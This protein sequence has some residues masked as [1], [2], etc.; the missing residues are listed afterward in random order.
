MADRNARVSY[1]AVHLSRMH[2]HEAMRSSHASR[3]SP[4]GA[5]AAAA[6]A[7]SGDAVVSSLTV[8]PSVRSLSLSFRILSLLPVSCRALWSLSLCWHRGCSAS[9]RRRRRPSRHA[10]PAAHSNPR[11]GPSA[12]Q[13]TP[14]R[15]VAREHQHDEG[16]EEI[17]EA[18]TA[19]RLSRSS[20]AGHWC[21]SSA[22]QPSRRSLSSCQRDVLPAAFH[23]PALHSRHPPAACVMLSSGT[24]GSAAACGLGVGVGSPLPSAAVTALRT[25]AQLTDSSRPIPLRPA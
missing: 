13:H 6:A 15:Q 8:V 11:H 14:M 7:P 2:G 20:E 16:L 19:V 22:H 17:G 23:P 10:P 24:S 3:L 5:G 1:E 18:T 21:S 25:R 12:P 4:A 9:A